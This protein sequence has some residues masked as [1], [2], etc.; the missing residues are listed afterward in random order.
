MCN[1]TRQ[2]KVAGLA[3]YRT[4]KALMGCAH[5][6]SKGVGH[7]CSRVPENEV[8]GGSSDVTYHVRRDARQ[9]DGVRRGFVAHPSP[10]H[11]LPRHVGCLHFLDHVAHDNVVHLFHRELCSVHQTCVTSFRNRARQYSL[12]PT[13][14]RGPWNTPVWVPLDKFTECRWDGGSGRYVTFQGMPRKVVRHQILEHCAR[15]HKRSPDSFHQHNVLLHAA[16]VR[17]LAYGLNL[18]GGGGVGGSTNTSD[19]YVMLE[20]CWKEKKDS[21][22]VPRKTHTH[23]KRNRDPRYATVR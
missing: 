3:C 19:C 7:Q 16:F 12:L 18:R 22:R 17:T 15:L 1:H 10:K 13:K 2:H 11:G 23:K 21:N 5:P 8:D 9:G 14:R 20:N 4:E 6:P